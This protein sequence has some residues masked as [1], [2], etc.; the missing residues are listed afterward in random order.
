MRA[1]AALQAKLRTMWEALRRH[2]TKAF[3][4]HVEGKKAGGS[5]PYAGQVFQ[6]SEKERLR[7]HATQR[8]K[9]TWAAV[10]KPPA[11]CARH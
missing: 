5:Q 8:A 2:A 4:A 3:K 10:L 11:W 9:D 1:P 7:K 6:D